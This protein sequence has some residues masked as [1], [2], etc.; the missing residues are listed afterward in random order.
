MGVEMVLLDL[1][2]YIG[3]ALFA[4]CAY[5]Q[6]YKVWKTNDTKSLSLSFILMWL[7]GEIFTWTYIAI[8]NYM[9][10]VFLWPLHLN[11]FFNGVSVVYLTYKKLKEQ[12]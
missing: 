1:I 2:G 9:T 6:A 4:L 5:P 12:K 11:Y 8:Q 10:G 7:F 3:A